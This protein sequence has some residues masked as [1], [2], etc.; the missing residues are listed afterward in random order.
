MNVNIKKDSACFTSESTVQLSSGDTKAMKDLAVGNEVLT[1]TPQGTKVL[2]QVL[3]FIHRDPDHVGRYCT[4]TTEDGVNIAMSESHLIFKMN[5]KT[6]SVESIHVS[7]I[8]IGDFIF[9]QAPDGHKLRA[10]KVVG[11]SVAFFKGAFAPVTKEGTMIVD[12]VLVS[13]YSDIN[14]HA[15]AH[16]LMAPLRFLYSVAPKWLG[17]KGVY[18]HEHLKSVF[19]PLGIRVLGKEKFYDRDEWHITTKPRGLY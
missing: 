13:C 2:T 4:V 10:V 16:S 14:D 6:S 17:S 9:V 18:I 1:Y 8:E 5:T 12:G 19:R 3:T 11:V 15:L 7:R